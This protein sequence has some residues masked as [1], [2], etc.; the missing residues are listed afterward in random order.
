MSN[1]L[2]VFLSCILDTKKECVDKIEY[3]LINKIVSEEI[4]LPVLYIDFLKKCSEYQSIALKKDC[5]EDSEFI[6][7]L[8]KAKLNVEEI[9]KIHDGIQNVTLLKKKIKSCT[10]QTVNDLFKLFPQAD[11]IKDCFENSS[12][13]EKKELLMSLLDD[14]ESDLLMNF[15][16]FK[17]L[18][19]YSIRSKQKESEELVADMPKYSVFPDVN[20]SSDE[21]KL[22]ILAHQIK[23]LV[24]CINKYHSIMYFRYKFDPKTFEYPSFNRNIL[25]EMEFPIDHSSLRVLLDNYNM[26][27]YNYNKNHL[28]TRI[29]SLYSSSQSNCSLQQDDI[30]FIEKILSGLTISYSRSYDKVKDI[31]WN[32]DLTIDK[33]KDSLFKLGEKHSPKTLI[34]S[35]SLNEAT[36]YIIKSLEEQ[37]DE[38]AREK[39][40]K[41]YFNKTSEMKKYIE[42]NNKHELIK[43]FVAMVVCVVASC[44]TTIFRI[45]NNKNHISRDVILLSAAFFVF[46]CFFIMISLSFRISDGHCD[47]FN[48]VTE[49]L[50]ELYLKI[51]PCS[52]T[53]ALETLNKINFH[54]SNV[55]GDRKLGSFIK[56]ISFL[57]IIGISLIAVGIPIKFYYFND[58]ILSTVLL[59][60]YLFICC[61]SVSICVYML[62]KSVQCQESKIY[63]FLSSTDFKFSSEELDIEKQSPLYDE[64]HSKVNCQDSFS[65]GSSL[66]GSYC[67]NQFKS[68]E[69]LI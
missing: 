41:I 25:N 31:K 64:N 2:P 36:D 60:V 68:E 29:Q 8:S 9:Q 40:R 26:I 24:L 53:E 23:Q 39:Y 3:D 54:K 10:I 34:K 57:S 18:N 56:N 1:I 27:L 30:K 33:S 16:T 12:F 45:M 14:R 15:K 58:N 69:S 32:D 48:E 47:K 7:L 38:G 43:F 50:F 61:I 52:D 28:I 55:E 63:S 6:T 17:D 46:Y 11:N 13:E 65:P 44:L 59:S 49:G 67:E 4:N 37:N 42:K 5:T 22:K 66:C 51:S 19:L 62:L 20:S 35:K 21:E